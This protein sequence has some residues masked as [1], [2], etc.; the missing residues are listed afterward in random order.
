MFTPVE[1]LDHLS[2]LYAG[3]SPGSVAYEVERV[4]L[5]EGRSN[6]GL[7]RLAEFGVPLRGGAPSVAEALAGRVD[8]GRAHRKLREAGLLLDE[9]E[10]DD[11]DELDGAELAAALHEE[12]TLGINDV[13]PVPLTVRL[14]GDSD[15]VADT[16]A[17][18][19]E[20]RG[21]VDAQRIEMS[22]LLVDGP[23]EAQM[24]EA[25]RMREATR[26]KAG[27]RR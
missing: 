4:R 10:T 5:R 25:N 17:L 11:L 18:A 2:A 19:R 3:A 7:E 9:P 13:S 26:R 14:D 1:V 24:T 20:L 6:A 8:V 15:A 22:G 27:D 12:I 23:T 16:I 21:E